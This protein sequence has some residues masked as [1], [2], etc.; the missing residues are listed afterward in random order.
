MDL[1]IA[2]RTAIIC[3]SSQGLGFACALA[4]ARAGVRVV[5]NG[6]DHAK[7]AGAAAQSR[8]GSRAAV[9]PVAAD[10][11]SADGR[12][13]LLAAAPA[14]DILVNNNAGPKPAFFSEVDQDAWRDVLEAN[15]IAPMMLTR[16]V[17]P[18]M[19]E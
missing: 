13:R 12:T 4:T 9:T 16:A 7:V 5:I 14:C 3:G 10:L 1:G 19:K 11:A 18:H 17:L 15:M 8:A 6:R 2:G